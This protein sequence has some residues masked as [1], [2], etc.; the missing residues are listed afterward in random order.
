MIEQIGFSEEEALIPNDKRL[1]RGFDFLRDYFAFPRRFLGFDLVELE[2]RRVAPESQDV[3]IIFAF[4]EINPRLAAAVRKEM[5]ALNAAPAVNLFEKTLDRIPVAT[6]RHEFPVIPDRSRPIDFETHRILQVFAHI[7]GRRRRRRWSRSTRPPRRAAPSGLCYTAR[8]LPRRISAE[9]RRYGRASDYAGVETFL[10]L[11]ERSDPEDLARVTELSVRAL[12]SNRHLAEH[13]PVGDGGADFRL[14][15]DVELELRCIAGPTRP[16]EP[17]MTAMFGKIDGAGAGEVAWRLV[18][19]LSFNHL[20]LEARG[21]EDSGRA[22][23]ETLALFA[24]AADNATERKIRGVRALNA[25]DVVRRMR[26]P[27]GAAAAR[28]LEVT[29]SLDEKAFEGS[30]PS[31]SAPCSTGS[32]PNMSR[33]TIL[34]RRSC[35]P[36]SAA[37]SCAGRRASANGA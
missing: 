32:S 24:D 30:A 33:S 9:E 14:L 4:D 3:E 26:Y 23:R 17:I 36:T 21:A 27:Q 37:K 5:F 35:A 10:S 8:R 22:L 11:G 13:L 18:N 15:D 28:G 19:M 2:E 7:P 12:C 25:R 1:F 29:V 6:N 31:C 20:G 34:P 16:R